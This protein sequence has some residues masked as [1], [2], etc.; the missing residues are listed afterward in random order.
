MPAYAAQMRRLLL[1]L[2]A[3]L[4]VA[5]CTSGTDS[6]TG[7]TSTPSAA[8]PTASASVTAVPEPSSSPSPSDSTGV[9]PSGPPVDISSTIT[10]M[11]VSGVQ[12]GTWPD[13][14]VPF[15][16]LRLWDSGTSWSQVEAV[17]G[18]YNWTLLDSAVA[19]AEKHGVKDILL[20]LGS[21]P[22]WNAKRVKSGDYPMPGAA[23]PPKDLQ[24]WDQF[25]TAVVKRYKGRITAYQIWNE[26]S[27][28]MFWNGSPELMA[29]LTKRAYDIIKSRDPKATVVAAST[30][31]RLE[32]AFDRFFPAY[33]DALAAYDWPV[34]VL[35]AHMYP[36]SRGST[37][38]RAAFIK[39]VTGAITAA[40]AP[41]LPVWDTEL[42]YGLAGPGPTNPKKTIGGARARNWVVQTAMDSLALGIARTYW[43]IWTQ[44]PYPLLGMQFTNASGAVRGLRV[45][46]QWL[47][48][49]TTTGC[50]EDGLVTACAVE[51]NGV[52]SLIAWSA[53]GST[54]W[55]PPSGYSEVCTVANACGA[56]EPPLTIG[57]TPVRLIP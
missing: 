37:D 51:K 1:P 55:T 17:K 32:G 18:T 34:D 15:G 45:V 42:N 43:Y 13:A 53:D 20:V 14:N 3:A 31:V 2:L 35:A 46:D 4:L 44:V 36:S 23:S 8:S 12:D 49:G 25:V 52:P 56:I 38:A 16:T 40:G 29:E 11:H 9:L 39:Q 57:E 54:A 47:V 6:S 21:T 33:L 10:G 22:T 26:A 48:G 5:S 30:T 27:L 28:A 24:A 41:D 50:A 19:N 7:G